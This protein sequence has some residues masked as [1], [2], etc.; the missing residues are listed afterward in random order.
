MVTPLITEISGLFVPL[1]ALLCVDD[2]DLY[3]LNS[4][5]DSAKDVVDK[6]QKILNAWHEVLKVTS[7]DLKLSKCY[8]KLHDFQWKSRKGFPVTS[9]SLKLTID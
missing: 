5:S 1:I 2:I 9:T 8:W 7:G 3:V 6:A 4:G